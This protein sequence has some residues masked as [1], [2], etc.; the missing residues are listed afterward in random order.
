VNLLHFLLIEHQNP[1]QF[2][3]QDRHLASLI[4]VTFVYFKVGRN[5]K[6]YCVYSFCQQ[7]VQDLLLRLLLQDLFLTDLAIL[8]TG[9]NISDKTAS[10]IISLMVTQVGTNTVLSFLTFNK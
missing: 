9:I 1:P 4:F 7:N 2:I 5:L 3:L 6:Y 10:V 8:A